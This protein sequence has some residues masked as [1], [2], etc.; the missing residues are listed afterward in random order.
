MKKCECGCGSEAQVMHVDL[1]N[2]HTYFLCSNCE[3]PFVMNSL[4]KKQ[5]KALIKNGH[6]T[7][8]F[9]LHEDFY[10]EETGEALQPRC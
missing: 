1:Y 10:D 9:A 6:T 4:S 8:E 7:K 5:F 3:I 2:G